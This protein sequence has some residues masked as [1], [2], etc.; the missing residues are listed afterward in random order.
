MINPN[1]L[2]SFEHND[3]IKRFCRARHAW[4]IS[5]VLLIVLLLSSHFLLMAQ[6]VDK[7]FVDGQ[8][9]LSLKP[10]YYTRESGLAQVEALLSQ[11]EIPL[12]KI[13]QPF[14]RTTQQT[15]WGNFYLIETLEVEAI[16]VYL[17][18][19]MALEE[20][21]KVDK[22]P[23]ATTSQ[24]TTPNDPNFVGGQQWYLNTV[25]AVNAWGLINP[26]ANNTPVVIAVIDDAVDLSHPD[27]AANLW[28]SGDQPNGVD[29]DGNGFVDDFRGYDF[30]DDDG[31]PTTPVWATGTVFSHGTHVAGIANGVTNNGVGISS[32]AYNARLMSLKCASDQTSNPN[33]FSLIAVVNGII[34]A[35]DN[36]ADIINM[37]LGTSFD[38]PPLEAAV[39]YAHDN[40]VIVVAAAGNDNT[41]VAS[42]PAA[43]TH[44]IAVAA[45][46]NMDQKASFSNFG[47][48]VDIT[49]PGVNIFSTVPNAGYGN[50]SG[51]SMACPLVVSALALMKRHRPDLP[52]AAIVDCLLNNTTNIDSQ[53]P[54][55][56]GSLG[57][58]RLHAHLAIQCLNGIIANIIASDISP[59]IGQ[60]VT[61]TAS[62]NTGSNISYTWNFGDNTPPLTTSTNTVTHIYNGVFAPATVTL[63]VSDGTNTATDQIGLVVAPCQLANPTQAHWY[64]YYFSAV[65][66]T[67][68]FPQA[69][70]SACQ[71]GTFDNPGGGSGEP[72]AV[73]SDDQG[74][75][76]FYTDGIRVWNSNHQQINNTLLMGNESMSQ[77][78]LIVPSP[79]YSNQ[80][81]IFHI[82]P[83]AGLRYS[84]VNV[85]NG[86][87]T[88]GTIN[89]PIQIN[90]YQ[91]YGGSL[92]TDER[93]TA[94]PHCDGFWIITNATTTTGNDTRLLVLNLSDNN[95]TISIT[96]QSN[97]FLVNQHVSQF[98]YGYMKAS[99]NGERIAIANNSGSLPGIYLID[100]DYTNGIAS[101]LRQ[102]ESGSRWGL[103]FSP[104][105]EIIYATSLGSG[106]IWQYDLNS[107][108]QPNQ[109]TGG[110]IYTPLPFG[111]TG[112]QLGPDNKVYIN[113]RG[114]ARLSTIH[115]PDD[116]ANPQFTF[117]DVNL[118]PTPLNCNISIGT[119]AGLPNLIDAHPALLDEATLTYTASNCNTY[120]FE[121][122]ACSASYLWNFGDPT[123]SSN[124]ASTQ[125]PTHVFSAPGIYTVTLTTSSGTRTATIV[126]ANPIVTITG[127]STLCVEAGGIHS[128]YANAGA[129]QYTYSWTVSGG[130]IMTSPTAAMI[131]VEWT[132]AI[133]QLSVVVTDANTGCTGRQTLNMTSDCPTTCSNCTQ[134]N[135]EVVNG[136]FEQ[137]ASGAGTFYSLLQTQSQQNCNIIGSYMIGAEAQDKCSSLVD[138][139]FDH[140]VGTRDGHYM[141]IDDYTNPS[142]YYIW[143]QQSVSITLGETYY[144]SFWQR[145]NLSAARPGWYQ[146]FVLMANGHPIDTISTQGSPDHEWIEYCAKWVADQTTTQAV[147]GIVRINNNGNNLPY[148]ID[149][150]SFGTC[151]DCEVSANFRTGL[152][153]YTDPWRNFIDQSTTSGT[154]L[155]WQWHFDDPASG[156]N[157]TS[158]LQNP[159][160]QFTANGTYN[161][162]LTVTAI[163]GGKVCTS[164]V[165]KEIT[166]NTPVPCKIKAA[167]TAN[168]NFVNN[169]SVSLINQSIISGTN[170]ITQWNWTVY[171]QNGVLLFQSSQ[172]NPTFSR[173][174]GSYVKICLEVTG[175]NGGCVAQVCKEWNNLV[176]CSIS[177]PRSL[178]GREAV[179]DMTVFPNP[180]HDEVEVVLSFDASPEQIVVRDVSGK[181]V[182]V[183][184]KHKA[185]KQ[186]LIDL[187]GLPG[188]VYYLSVFDNNEWISQTIIKQ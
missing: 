148:G 97:L 116:L 163:Q 153:N 118:N 130:T 112:I 124:S 68:G 17:E 54:G 98:Q 18:Q 140:T 186:L 160:H 146:D 173:N 55:F 71:N 77:G 10:E 70:Y 157:N 123:S 38:F 103:T 6:T 122:T 33:S 90:G 170:T 43:Y 48:W 115:F 51:T 12:K 62:Q 169:C 16:D 185:D 26:T 64:F 102:I 22:V 31:N 162:C 44:A 56:V 144:F 91:S 45:S 178:T 59:C 95:G 158:T 8:L 24:L 120:H 109:I 127:A 81:L 66:F 152:H 49:A 42:F 177:G 126:I 133:G 80:Y 114:T 9:L 40:D 84:V 34:Y 30:A 25:Q 67:Q 188:G 93:I 105:S 76:L 86:L 41:N 159:S 61:L 179:S 117:A 151:L 87:A 21:A 50:K 107:N 11:T 58:G 28:N 88:M 4:L 183:S 46:D 32:L 164:T 37:S 106:I 134:T 135:D 82:S 171:N 89:V 131:D 132:S 138:N 73:M 7:N 5:H 104:N 20:V 101:N 2:F 113:N 174:F 60:I 74:N 180:T 145:R 96:A 166:I 149:D 176:A 72:S 19:L 3:R 83:N 147:I 168:F 108:A 29:D 23:L 150:I 92:R 143:A 154:I 128:Y 182:T 187:T 142:A 181:K 110:N 15:Y 63:T 111:F 57:S 175:N 47:S 65:D 69:D 155:S 100:F 85:N 94:I 172:P 137:G 184:I 136:N 1:S 36:G 129:G 79:S 99:P 14:T 161:V 156:V 119:G 165:C 52:N 139:L 75:L 27:L 13:S 39:N 141:I 35:T 78:A 125:N 53:N 167:F 121:A